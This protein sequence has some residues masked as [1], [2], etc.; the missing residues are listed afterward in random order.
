MLNI[1][2]KKFKTFKKKKTK[3]FMTKANWVPPTNSSLKI[4]PTYH[5]C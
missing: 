3:Y 5:K 2:L 1:L 4:E